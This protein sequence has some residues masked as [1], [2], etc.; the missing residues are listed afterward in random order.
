MAPRLMT[1][2]QW[3]RSTPWRATLPHSC[4]D[5]AFLWMTRGQGRCLIAGR[6]RGIGVHTALSIPAGSLFALQ[7]SS[8][9]SAQSFGLVCLLPARGPVFLPDEPHLLR[10]TD[11]RA[12]TDMTQLLETMQREQNEAKPFMK[13]AL[14]AQGELL[15]VWLRRAMV[16]EENVTPPTASQRLVDAYCALVERDHIHG[17]SMQDYAR[18]LGV[19]PTHLTRVCKATTG[20]TALEILTGRVLYAA[21]DLLETTRLPANQIAARL[22][23]RSAAY[24]SRFIHNHTGHAPRALR[25]VA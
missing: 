25:K 5:Q 24:F 7:P 19:T 11:Q 20:M 3:T 13:D 8:Q 23:F 12:Q 17:L 4:E 22:G 1:L 2:A 9:N 21:R 16:A 14:T 6:R 18:R 10:I 15:T